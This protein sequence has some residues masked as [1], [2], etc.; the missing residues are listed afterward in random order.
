MNLINGGA[1]DK[2]GAWD[3]PGTGG[4]GDRKPNCRM[5]ADQVRDWGK[6]LGRDGCALLSWK[7]DSAFLARTDNQQAISEVAIFL[8]GL[9]RRPCAG[10]R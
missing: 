6:I 3:C 8:A 7:Y 9:P 4:L 5:T 1:Q 2:I 10:T